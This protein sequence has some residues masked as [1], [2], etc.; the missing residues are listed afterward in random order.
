VP[1]FD[2]AEL[3]DM[4]HEMHQGE[5]QGTPVPVHDPKAGPT[6]DPVADRWSKLPLLTFKPRVLD[7]NLVITAGRADP[8]HGAFDVLRTKLV[9]TLADKGW[10]RVGVTSPTKG[11]GKSF[12]AVNLAVSLSRYED[13]RTVLL[14]M[15]LRRPAVARIFGARDP[16]AMGDLLQ[17]LVPPEAFLRRMGPNP[18]GIGPSLAV[19]LNGRTE[20]SAAELLFRPATR[21]AL[22]RLEAALEPRVVLLDLPPALAQD[23]VIALKPYLD[24]V[25]MVAGGGTTT[26]RELRETTRRL[27]EDFPILGVVLNKGQG[28]DALGYAY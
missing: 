17:G 4:I 18:L 13:C 7:R 27:G 9:Q 16:G 22:G 21:E 10:R 6:P 23:D 15:D 1:P 2:K 25:L 12:T 3:R 19:G 11:C 20:V 8:A 26:P 28:R 14:D 24:C 5:P